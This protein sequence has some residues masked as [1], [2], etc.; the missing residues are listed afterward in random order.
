MT[1]PSEKS[2]GRH[3]APALDDARLDRQVAAIAERGGLGHRR[4]RDVR[5]FLTFAMRTMCVGVVALAVIVSVTAVRSRL[6]ARLSAEPT[7]GALAGTTFE[8][9]AGGETITLGDGSRAVLEARSKLTLLTVR[10]E[11]VRVALERG[12]VDLDV[13]HADG[14]QFVVD[15]RGYE[16]R[17]L[18]TRFSVLLG[19][20][21][22]APALEVRVARGR[23]RVTR[24]SEEG[25]GET[26][27]VRVLDA[28]ETWS[29]A[30]VT[31]PVPESEGALG[32]RAKPPAVAGIGESPRALLARA[33]AF[34]AANDPRAAARLFDALRVRHRSDPRAGLAAFELGRLRLDRLDDPRGAAEAFNDAIAVAPDAPFREDAQAR[35]VEA[36]DASRD[37]SRCLDAQSAYLLRYPRG[38]H[39]DKIAARC[40]E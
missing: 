37:H 34:R 7:G 15:A 40:P 4:A 39:R 6:I 20:T 8:A 30:P 32:P 19:E 23:V 11:M 31:V 14:K 1:P 12:G 27:D 25:A 22:G 29:T 2:L 5:R 28:G 13:V 26:Q 24:G 10:P 17:V 35:L 18:G 36:Y 3:L 9:P 21:E 16:V 38:V 33:E